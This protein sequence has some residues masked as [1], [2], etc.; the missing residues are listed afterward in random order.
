MWGLRLSPL[1]GLL[2]RW[3]VES[4]EVQEGVVDFRE[5]VV[6]EMEGLEKRVAE[7]GA[8]ALCVVQDEIWAIQ[9]NRA[10]EV[11]CSGIWFACR[12]NGCGQGAA[13]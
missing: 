2:S 10:E 5:K 1:V 4:R 3:R 8:A 7:I 9:A 6:S 12:W 11:Q 13:V